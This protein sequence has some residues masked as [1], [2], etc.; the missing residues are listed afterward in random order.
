MHG[1]VNVCMDAWMDACAHVRVHACV[2]VWMCG[3]VHECVCECVDGWMDVQMCGSVAVWTRGCVDGCMDTWMDV[4]MHG[5]VDAWTCGCVSVCVD[6]LA[7]TEVNQ[8]PETGHE[9]KKSGETLKC[10][11]LHHP[12]TTTALKPKRTENFHDF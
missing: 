7:P 9:A 12:F 8:T 5:C 10:S 3:C 2:D 6:V 11:H 1:C 4:W